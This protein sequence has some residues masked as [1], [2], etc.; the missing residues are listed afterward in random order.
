MGVLV[1]GLFLAPVVALAGLFLHSVEV[2]RIRRFIPGAFESGL[3]ILSEAVAERVISG[4]ANCIAQA[5]PRGV[6]FVRRTVSG[7]FGAFP[8]ARIVRTGSVAELQVRLGY[9]FVAFYLATFVFFS[10]ATMLTQ[11]LL[12]A[13]F[14]AASGLAIVVIVRR[15]RA[16]G[17]N[18]A[19]S[20]WRFSNQPPNPPLQPTSGATS[21]TLE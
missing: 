14:V 9:G 2:S 6:L 8:A 12:V 7:A 13:L 4:D 11:S 20:A 3:T 1:F 5:H 19:S 21:D 16:W 18:A 17:R 15:E 10:F